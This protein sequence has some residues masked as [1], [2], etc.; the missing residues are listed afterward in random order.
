[1]E[2]TEEDYA[3]HQQ[4]VRKLPKV[5]HET[6]NFITQLDQAVETKA[7]EFTEKQKEN[8]SHSLP[9]TTDSGLA[10]VR[11]INAYDMGRVGTRPLLA[12]PCKTESRVQ[13]R[14]TFNDDQDDNEDRDDCNETGIGSV[15]SEPLNLDKTIEEM[16]QGS[17][18][19]IFKFRKLLNSVL[20][21]NQD[22]MEG[23]CGS[24]QGNQCAV[25]QIY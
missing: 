2:Y 5:I 22:I 6:H 20:G 16:Q 8:V 9:G 21:E 14:D 18:L 10:N 7:N 13:L 24:H 25:T 15:S 1:M 23:S 11:G 19:A 4:F 12:V 17:V 3:K